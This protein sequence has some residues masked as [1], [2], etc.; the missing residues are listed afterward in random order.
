M[1]TTP[2]L[3]ATVAHIYDNRIV[4]LM[5]NPSDPLWL[6]TL[7]LTNDARNGDNSI[8]SVEPGTPQYPA[9]HTFKM[10][11]SF[12]IMRSYAQAHKSLWLE[13]VYDG[14]YVAYDCFFVEVQLT[15][16]ERIT[17]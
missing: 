9:G 6:G 5:T 16:V 2:A 10:G 15:I 13:I 1:P 12:P 4:L 17:P 14:D 8:G 7:T 11:G 3:Q